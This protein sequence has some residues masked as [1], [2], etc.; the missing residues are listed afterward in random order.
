MSSRHAAAQLAVHGEEQQ[1]SGTTSH[2]S[3]SR[4]DRLRST[5]ESNAFSTSTPASETFL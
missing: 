4:S 3:L 5:I 1:L 2:G